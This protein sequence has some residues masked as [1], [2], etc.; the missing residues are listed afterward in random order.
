MHFSRENAENRYPLK[1]LYINVLL[2]PLSMGVVYLRRRGTPVD[3]AT[4]SNL[5][6]RAQSFSSPLLLALSLSAIDILSSVHAHIHAYMHTCT[7]GTYTPY[8]YVNSSFTSFRF[9]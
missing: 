5:R 7:A 9:L 1:N 6:L 4:E 2:G 8:Q 3:A